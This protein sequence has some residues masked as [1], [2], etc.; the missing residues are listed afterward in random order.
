[1]V[2][3]VAPPGQPDRIGRAL[4]LH[5]ASLEQIRSLANLPLA[6]TP[7]AGFATP[8]GSRAARR[9]IE[10]LLRSWEHAAATGAQ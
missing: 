2:A 5:S 10:T 3:Q 8:L 9:V 6:H 7:E 4:Q 1:V